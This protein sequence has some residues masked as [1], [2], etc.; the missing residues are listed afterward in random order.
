MNTPQVDTRSVVV[1]REF[2]HP[3]EKLWRALTQPHLLQEWLM[4][5]DFAAEKGH[6]FRLN[7]E[8][9]GTIDCE[10]LDIIPNRRLSYSWNF[11][12]DDPAFALQS[13]VTFTLAPTSTGTQL[14]M[15]QSG[16]R[17]DQTQAFGGARA[18]WPQFFG[19]LELLLDRLDPK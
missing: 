18:G 9:G 15:E 6:Q 19:K 16:F 5:N 13:I 2:P 10:V 14:R 12:N 4:R 17:S 11:V 7:G 1:E 3:P 8:W